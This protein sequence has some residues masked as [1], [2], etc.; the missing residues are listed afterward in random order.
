MAEA[1]MAEGGLHDHARTFS[2]IA[3]VQVLMVIVL[4]LKK[5]NDRRELDMGC[6]PVLSDQ[7]REEI[8]NKKVTKIDKD[9]GW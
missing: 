9:L 2:N 8:K 5:F 6:L 3:L 7:E 4:E 1:G